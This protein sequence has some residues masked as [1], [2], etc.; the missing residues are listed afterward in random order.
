[1]IGLRLKEIREDKKLSQGDIERISGLKRCYVSRVENGHTVPAVETLEKLARALGVPM[2]RLFYEGEELPAPPQRSLGQ[3]KVWGN[4]GKP[5]RYLTQ[6]ALAL[7]EMTP[8]NRDLILAVAHRIVRR[9]R[10]RTIDAAA[11]L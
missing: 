9:P 11:G 3:Q 4:S 6:L 8:E 1:M 7:Q 10:H 5:R 2:Y